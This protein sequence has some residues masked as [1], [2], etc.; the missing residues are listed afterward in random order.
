MTTKEPNDV[1]GDSNIHEPPV[2]CQIGDDA[3]FPEF[4][5]ATDGTEAL[6]LTHY[7]LSSLE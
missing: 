3:R 2:G 7:N 6:L 4:L 5:Q 1:L